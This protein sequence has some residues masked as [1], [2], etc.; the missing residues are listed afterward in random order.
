MAGIPDPK[1]IVNPEQDEGEPAPVVVHVHKH[2]ARPRW[3]THLNCRPAAG[4]E[5]RPIQ[6]IARSLG[7]PVI[8]PTGTGFMIDA[9][10]FDE[11]VR[12]SSGRAAVKRATEAQNEDA[13]GLGAAGLR[14]VGGRR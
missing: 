9:D 2:A 13:E 14:V 7:I 12:T 3:Y 4:L 8:R 10:A 1:S 6:A 11:A 5:G